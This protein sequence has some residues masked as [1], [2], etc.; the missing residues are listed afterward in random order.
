MYV[1]SWHDA[2]IIWNISYQC[3]FANTTAA[4]NY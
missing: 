3:W 2:L 1:F 4:E